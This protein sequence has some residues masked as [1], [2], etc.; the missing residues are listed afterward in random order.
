MPDAA[1]PGRVPMTLRPVLFAAAV[2]LA[3]IL[4]T[5]AL[6]DSTGAV[7]SLGWWLGMLALLYLAAVSVV[8]A[9]IDVR[10]RRLPDAI[11]WPSYVVGI[12]LLGT[13]ALLSRDAVTPLRAA[14]GMAFLYNLYRVARRLDPAGLGGGDVKLA[15]LLGW[16]LGW[17]GWGSLIVGTLAAFLCGGLFALALIAIRRARRRTAFAFGPWMLLG[18]WVGILWGQALWGHGL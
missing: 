6:L 16:Y 17:L 3:V 11:V 12:L 4:V 1:V 18:S 8:L 2:T 14:I 10:A 15:G 7:A 13:A 5:A 9:V